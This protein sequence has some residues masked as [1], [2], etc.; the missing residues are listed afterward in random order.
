MSGERVIAA[1]ADSGIDMTKSK[2]G[3]NLGVIIESGTEAFKSEF[4]FCYQ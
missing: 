3:N 4:G 2:L 1:Q